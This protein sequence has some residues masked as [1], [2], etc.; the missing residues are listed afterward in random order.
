[1]NL[2]P[3]KANTEVANSEVITVGNF[4]STQYSLISYFMN[5]CVEYVSKQNKNYLQVHNITIREN[6][7]HNSIHH[8]LLTQVSVDVKS[9]QQNVTTIKTFMKFQIP[10][11]VDNCFFILNENRFVPTL[12]I[13]DQPIVIKK[14]SI[15][16]SSTFNSITI[17]DRLVTFMGNNI[18]ASYFLDLFLSNSDSEEADLKREIRSEFSILNIPISD[19]DLLNYFSNLLKCDADRDEIQQYFHN[20]FFD[21][22]TKMLYQQCY[23]LEEKDLTITKLLGQMINLYRTQHPDTFID[24]T[25]KRV[26]F[27]EVLLWPIFKRIASVAIQASR[28]LYVNEIAMDQMS[29]VKHFYTTLHN[30]FIYDNSNA[31]D[32][33]I[34]HKA[35][36]LGPNAERAP[37]NIANLHPTHFQ[38]IC[39]ISVSSQNPGETIFIISEA[40]LD[41]FGRFI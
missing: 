20:I 12:Y 41:I 38:K 37:S 35:H 5:L 21:D 32:V 28:G 11:L 8:N 24:L 13:L 23:N 31:Y 34:Q 40:K 14:D 29:L 16:L 17:Y 25:Q 4:R 15:K 9:T 30:K 3:K 19:S 18:P 36:M 33:I 39:P 7:T 6:S 27:I 22:Y 2:L 10:T 1:L 26:V